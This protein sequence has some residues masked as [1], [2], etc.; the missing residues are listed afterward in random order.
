MAKVMDIAVRIKTAY[1][2]LDQIIFTVR[3]SM[4]IGETDYRIRTRI[5]VRWRERVKLTLAWQPKG[6]QSV[7]EMRLDQLRFPWLQ[8]S[9]I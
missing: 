6:W 1:I 7:V 3:M 4:I 9:V 8:D 2:S 5:R